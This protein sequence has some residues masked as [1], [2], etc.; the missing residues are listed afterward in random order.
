MVSKVYG[1]EISCLATEL[2]LT[3]AWQASFTL[4]RPQIARL[5]DQAELCSIIQYRW[6]ANDI[7]G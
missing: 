7:E 2:I 1:G 6:K 3:P 5:A 4:G